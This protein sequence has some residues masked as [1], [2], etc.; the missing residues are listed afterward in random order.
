MRNLIFTHP[1]VWHKKNSGWYHCE[2]STSRFTNGIS[3]EF[4]SEKAKTT[5]Y[6]HKE[7]S[8]LWGKISLTQTYVIH[9]RQK[10]EHLRILLRTYTVFSHFERI[11]LDSNVFF[12][13]IVFILLFPTKVLTPKNNFSNQV[14]KI[15][16]AYTYI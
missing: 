4:N 3:T 6:V 8:S 1:D 16:R 15:I 2:L 9:P 11:H 12:R 7:R 5:K 13:W 14:W 10:R